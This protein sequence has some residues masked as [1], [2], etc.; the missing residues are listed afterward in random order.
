MIIKTSSKY[1]LASKFYDLMETGIERRLFSKLR[2]KVIPLA[3]GDVLEIG[4]GT[5][6]NLQYYKTPVKVSAIDFSRGMLKKAEDKLK[7]L[8]RQDIEL[9]LMDAQNLDFENNRFDSI[10]AAFVFC[11]VPDPVKGFNE[12]Y[13][14]LKPGGKAYF[15][16]HMLTDNSFI[17]S[18]LFIMNI[19]SKIFLGTSM[20]RKTE[21]N[22]K[23]AGFKIISSERYLNGIVRV[24]VA[25]KT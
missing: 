5:G 22:I 18:I 12:A 14:V 19:F 8:E 11:T 17:N 23:E 21:N 24:I 6:K 2:E 10:T 16:E 7:R 20:I 4:V 1:N 25:E 9:I 13:R 15:I 3:S